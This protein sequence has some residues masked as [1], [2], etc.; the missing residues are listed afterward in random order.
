[1]MERRT[2]IM[3]VCILAC[4]GL[5]CCVGA[6]GQPVRGKRFPIS[7]EQV[8]GA[9]RSGG[10]DIDAEHITHMPNVT[11]AEESP[12][13]SIVRVVPVDSEEVAVRLACRDASICLPFLVFV[14][15][16]RSEA[17]RFRSTT[18]SPPQVKVASASTH[19]LMRAGES[20]TFLIESD[21]VRITMNVVCLQ[22]GQVGDTIRV[23]TTDRKLVYRAQVIAPGIVK[24][25]P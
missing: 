4:L 20:V 6:V 3:R 14:R 10:L 12:Q 22:A 8:A 17:E 13:L 19:P 7:S 24:G 25:L 16:R 15:A 11:A 5:S 18:A 1:M 2:S 23:A 9:L 21:D